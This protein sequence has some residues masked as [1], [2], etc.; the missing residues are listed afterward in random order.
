LRILLVEDEPEMAAALGAA[1]KNYDMVVDHFSTLADAEEAVSVNAYGAVLLDRQLPDGDGLTLIPKLRAKGLSMPIIVLTARGDLVDRVAGL[2]GGADDYLGKP[3]AV[4]ELIARL[5][6]VLRRPADMSAETVTL[7]R[8]SFDF[9]Q[10]EACVDNEPLDLPRRELLVLEA[11]LRRMGRTV[12]RPSLE[13]AVYSID[14]EIQSN[15]LD[16]HV[17]RLRRKL[18]ET[19]AGIEIHAIRGVGYLLKR[20]S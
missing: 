8:L 4:E 18:S 20:S 16:T 10:R 5:R 2:N 11:L 6:A 19:R 14:D 15:A 3:F 13:E 12:S 1:L 7:G 9:G 17:S